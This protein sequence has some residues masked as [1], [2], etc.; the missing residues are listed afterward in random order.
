M[1][2]LDMT[3][4]QNRKA[5]VQVWV[6]PRVEDSKIY[7][8]ADSDSALT[9]VCASFHSRQTKFHLHDLHAMWPNTS[10]PAFSG[11]GNAALR[12]R[13]SNEP[14]LNYCNKQYSV[15]CTVSVQG[16]AA[17]LV[18]GL[19]DSAADDIVAIP[20]DFIDRLGLQQSLTPSR[21]NGFLNMFRLM[22]RKSLELVQQQEH[23]PQ[24][25]NAH[26]QLHNAHLH[27]ADNCVQR[28]FCPTL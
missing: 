3:S 27:L 1:Q 9:K 25:V 20:P 13:K 22:Q 7:W 11:K 17:L 2:W 14:A 12:F 6:H 10:F 16:L 24:E 8:E 5:C 15:S 23:S 21:N 4:R 18:Q 26:L 28:P 19:S